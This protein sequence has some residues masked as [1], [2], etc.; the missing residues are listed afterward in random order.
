M[1]TITIFYRDRE[2]PP[3][4]LHDVEKVV[5]LKQPRTGEPEYRFHEARYPYTPICIAVAKIEKIKIDPVA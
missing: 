5:Y 4:T 3:Q 1:N 2:F